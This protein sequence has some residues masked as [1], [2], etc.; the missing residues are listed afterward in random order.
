MPILN[1]IV[2]ILGLAVIVLLICHYLRL[3]TIVGLLIAGVIAGPHGLGLVYSVNEVENVAAIGVILLLFTI[4]IELSLG[5]LLQLR[6]AFLLGGSLQVLLTILV[7]SLIA[8][9]VGLPANKSVFI[10]FLISLS[11]S[12][13]VLKILQDKVEID[14]PHGRTALAISIFQ[15][16]AIVPMMLLTP[17]LAGTGEEYKG[18]FLL[19]FLKGLGII[20]I[21]IFSAN[22]L[23]PRILHQVVRT[24]SR[25]LFLLTIVVICFVVAWSTAS[26]GLSLALGAFLAG[27]IISESRYSHHVLGNIIPFRD[28]FT[29]IFFIS[30][31]ML[32][33]TNFLLNNA[34][35]I[36]LC[37]LGVLIIKTLLVAMVTALLM[38]PLRV[39]L[40]VGIALS[41]V[42]EFSFVLS[43][44][45]YQ[46]AL[47]TKEIY[48]LFLAVTIITMALTPFMMSLATPIIN[49]ALNLPL[50]HRLKRGLLLDPRLSG[51]RQQLELKDHLIIVG[52]GVNGRNVARAA[53]VAGIPYVIIEMNPDTVI[54]ERKKREPIYFG[55]ATNEIVL[56][57]AKITLAR[58]LVVTIADPAATQRIVSLARHL[59]PQ[60]HIIARTRFLQEL[61]QLYKLGANE[62]IPEEFETSIEIFTRVLSKYLI[63]RDEIEKFVAEVRADN[64]EMFR[65]ISVEGSSFADLKLQ[66]PDIEITTIRVPA[67]SPICGRSLAEIELRKKYGITLLAIRRGSQIIANPDGATVVF[68]DDILMILGT[69]DK[70]SEVSILFQ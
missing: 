26:V 32:L 16:V 54:A 44:I 60:L 50:P 17:I 61:P 42:G 30:I 6:K 66:H 43:R 62:V 3:P 64:Y 27:L 11:S 51:E 33:D 18:G 34:G 68:P 46:Y 9:Q 1:E 70:I 40:L 59:S 24:K 57:F 7:V 49:L 29:S 45:G 41:Q 47:L 21:V 22:M 52:F 48:Q 28:V 67:T 53:K 20:I 37:V 10:G 56:Q 58:V 14:S 4:G 65:T 69:P 63:P 39:I 38:L 15:D 2:I 19:P 5:N 31:G 13:I 25:E 35:L 36:I 55:D 8:R 23:V 12:A